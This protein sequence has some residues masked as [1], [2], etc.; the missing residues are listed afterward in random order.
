MAPDAGGPCAC[1]HLT[2]AGTGK[3]H[4]R[5]VMEEQCTKEGQ[6]LQGKLFGPQGTWACNKKKMRASKEPKAKGTMQ[7][8]AQKALSAQHCN[9]CV[10]SD[11]LVCS[12]CAKVGSAQADTRADQ[13]QLKLLASIIKPVILKTDVLNIQCRQRLVRLSSVE[14]DFLLTAD[15]SLLLRQ[16]YLTKAC[17]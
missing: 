17:N 16:F 3:I 15:L 2:L 14:N 13:F 9:A 8:A 11:F 12:M 6:V 7:P 10:E 4:G 5:I 1:T